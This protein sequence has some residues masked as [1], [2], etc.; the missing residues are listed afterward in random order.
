MTHTHV[1]APTQFVERT[2]S[3]S[4]TVA[5]TDVSRRVFEVREQT[6]QHSK[7]QF[8]R[9]D[10]SDTIVTDTSRLQTQ[11]SRPSQVGVYL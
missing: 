6:S 1:T 9:N 5:G 3:A 4:L 2:E 10:M 8:R 7:R 11:S